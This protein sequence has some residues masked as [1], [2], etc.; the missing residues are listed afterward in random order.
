MTD[1]IS[2]AARADVVLGISH[3]NVRLAACEI[4]DAGVRFQNGVDRSPDQT[5]ELVDNFGRVMRLLGVVDSHMSQL[6]WATSGAVVEGHPDFTSADPETTTLDL[7]P[8]GA[9]KLIAQG[10]AISAAV[11][12][13]A[14][15]DAVDDVNAYSRFLDACTLFVDYMGVFEDLLAVFP[16]GARP[17]GNESGKP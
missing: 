17:Q 8:F 7:R 3:R 15:T 6:V 4:H 13:I 5:S 16:A 14:D 1:Q 9:K 2:E 11:K 10:Q 12:A